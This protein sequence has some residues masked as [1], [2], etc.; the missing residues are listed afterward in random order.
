MDS[1]ILLSFVIRY[2]NTWLY[3]LFWYYLAIRIGMFP[4]ETPLS[5]Q[6][7]LGIQASYKAPVDL[8]RKHSD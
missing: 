2:I 6:L 8:C 4:V 7:S 5:A 3:I 1:A